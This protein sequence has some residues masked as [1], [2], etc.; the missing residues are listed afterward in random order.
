MNYY[1]RGSPL[2]LI[3]TPEDEKL[4]SAKRLQLLEST[5]P[6]HITTKKHDSFFLNLLYTA[7]QVEVRLQYIY[8]YQVLEYAAFYYID[9][10]IKSSLL[11]I[12]NTPDIQ[13]EPEKYISEMLDKITELNQGDEAKIDRIVQTR[14]NPEI[15][16]KEIEH[17]KE[18][19][20]KEQKFDGGYV[21]DPC[22]SGDMTYQGFSVAWHP[23]LIKCLRGVRNALVHGRERRVANIISPT[24]Q[25]DLKLRSLTPII[26]RMAEQVIIYD[27]LP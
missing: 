14:C 27:S 25:N 16:W 15:L 26:H 11:R 20:L 17:N 10:N 3:H 18:F 23:K 12:I 4:K 7:L 19:F 8:Y 5:F 24:K 9:S 22:I 13:S 21:L 2:I 6:Q 1:D